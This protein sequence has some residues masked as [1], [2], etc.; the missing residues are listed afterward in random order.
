MNERKKPDLTLLAMAIY[1][2]IKKEA[3]QAREKE[4]A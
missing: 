3:E 1:K 4:E 2:A